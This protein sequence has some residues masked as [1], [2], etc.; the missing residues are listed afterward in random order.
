MKITTSRFGDIEVPD[1]SILT[2]PSGI[3]G[4]P[5]SSR[6][7]LFDHDREAPFKWLQSVDEPGLA[8]VV[9]DPGVFKADYTMSL[10][11][12]QTGEIDVQGGDVPAV[13]VILTVP[14]RDPSRIT[15]NL[16]GPL[17]VN[18]RTRLGMQVVLM[19]EWPTRYQVFPASAKTRP[20]TPSEEESI[21]LA[22][23]C[24]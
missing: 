24:P 5:E 23:G 2:F 14:G 9:I 1:Q 17:V 21:P 6:Y 19:D 22:V 12:A 18:S 8:F 3:I 13:L 20:A 11:D 10:T 7:V 4:F 16:R 15:A